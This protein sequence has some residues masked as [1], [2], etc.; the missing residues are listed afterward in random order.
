MGALHDTVADALRPLPGAAPVLRRAAMDD[1]EWP[2]AEGDGTD[3]GALTLY[4]L[5]KDGG[6]SPPLAPL[7]GPSTPDPAA[8]SGAGKV[9]GLADEE[10]RRIAHPRIGREHGLE[11]GEQGTRHTVERRAESLQQSKLIIESPVPLRSASGSSKS[12]PGDS[13]VVPVVASA[14]VERPDGTVN[15]SQVAR[16]VP[17]E[18][19]QAVRHRVT[20]AD[21]PAAGW[22]APGVAAPRSGASAEA[23]TPRGREAPVPDAPGTPAHRPPPAAPAAAR[24]GRPSADATAPGGLRIGRIEVTVLAD[25]PPARPAAAA[26]PTD[27]HFLSRHYLRRT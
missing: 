23:L 18:D 24:Q 12:A 17:S 22:P 27:S 4:R 11:R 25:A 19:L 6:V 14:S 1:A 3:N 10:T 15:R 13:A 21:A 8:P 2:T 5:Q 7:H 20:G 9:G 26:A 16:G